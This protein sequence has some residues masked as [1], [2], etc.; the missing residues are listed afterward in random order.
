MVIFGK[1][2]KM[3][4]IIPNT[5]DLYECNENGEIKRVFSSVSNGKGNSKRIIGLKPLKPKTKKNGYQEVSLSLPGKHKMFYVHRLVATTFIGNI[6]SGFVVNHKDGNKKNNKISN[7]EIVTYSENSSH[8]FH[9]LKNK[10]KPKI[11]VEHHNAKLNDNIVLQIRDFY[12][13]NNLKSTILLFKNIPKS[14]ICKIV[15]RQTWKHL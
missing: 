7:L 4:K 10:L 8:S 5:F 13:K 14:T 2:N 15:Y 9:V 1:K 6:P 11:G 3:F 12:K